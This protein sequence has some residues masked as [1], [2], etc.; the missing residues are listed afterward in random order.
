MAMKRIQVS[1]EGAQLPIEVTSFPD[2]CP[3]CH[4]GL[5]VRFRFGY[6]HD[7]D[8]DLEVIF[9]CPREE[10]RH[11]FIGYYDQMY[12]ARGRDE[13][14]VFSRVAPMEHNSRDF[15]EHISSTSP[16]FNNIYNQA[17]ISE[18]LGLLEIAGPGYRKALEFLIKDYAISRQPEKAEDIKHKLL[19]TVINEY[20]ADT[21]IKSTAKRAAWLGND[22]THYYKK[23]AN[24]DLGD[25]KT[26]IEPT[27]R[28]IES[29]EMTVK[30][31]EDMAD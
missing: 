13:P 22:E 6:L 1:T 30:Y 21:R 4:K 24:Q 2:T 7:D 18:E 12:S 25:L 29:E 26:L 14:Y 28:W 23:W 20:V 3:I 5:D 9:Q 17:S 31:E 8:F 16:D 15:G 19:G 11:L 27:I 10:C